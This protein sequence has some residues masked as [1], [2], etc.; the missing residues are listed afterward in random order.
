MKRRDL[1]VG[2]GSV[3]LVSGLFRTL[4][5]E[6]APCPPPNFGVTGEGAVSTTCGTAGGSIPGHISDAAVGQWTPIGSN[7]M[8]NVAYPY[9]NAPSG[10]T[11]NLNGIM[12]AWSGA[13]YNPTVHTLYV[14]GGGHND[15]DG[16]EWYAFS[17]QTNAWR[18]MD[19]PTLLNE[20]DYPSGQFPDGSPI[21]I[22]TYDTLGVNTLTGR[23]YRLLGG[24]SHANQVY[25]WNPALAPSKSAWSKKATPSLP[26][27]T[28]GC[29]AWAPDEGVFYVCVHDGGT[30][31]YY[32]KYNP[33][34]NVWT[35]IANPGT[36]FGPDKAGAYSP[37]R[38][39]F[40]VLKGSTIEVLNCNSGTVTTPSVAGA[41]FQAR[42]I[43]YDSV[44]DRFV[45]YS[46]EG[47]DRRQMW[48]IN[49]STWTSTLISPT[50]ASIGGVAGDY[51]GIFGRFA[52]CA[53]YDV[54]I[55]V[56]SVSGNVYVYKPVGWSPP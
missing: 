11:T 34:T 29:S 33:T 30:W 39:I 37:S 24:G 28:S 26:G 54:F 22:H 16:N 2:A 20:D 48:S 36:A 13:C 40:V 55:A 27:S 42:G 9:G 5:V 17:L 52:Y 25:E 49:P 1:L 7:T 47:A 8:N 15:Y 32:A 18:R 35:N 6:A 31:L 21:P 46:D 23:V 4:G 10:F 12:T 51:R 41:A 45:V 38:R 43:D 56:N 44:R 14:H 19:D 3:G 53:D 50:G